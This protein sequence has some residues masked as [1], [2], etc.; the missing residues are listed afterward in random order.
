MVPREDHVPAGVGGGGAASG[1]KAPQHRAR[2]LRWTNVATAVCGV[3]TAQYDTRDVSGKV[4]TCARHPPSVCPARHP[5]SI[6]P[7]PPT[8]IVPIDRRRRR[9]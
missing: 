2:T 9:G 1:A 4:L 3:S 8:S 7:S 6:Y 5:A